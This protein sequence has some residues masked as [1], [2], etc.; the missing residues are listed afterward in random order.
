[1]EHFPNYYG[2]NKNNTCT[3]RVY[4]KILNEIPLSKLTKWYKGNN[5]HERYWRVSILHRLMEPNFLLKH[6]LW[7][8][9]PFVFYM[10]NW[11]WWKKNNVN[12]VVLQSRF[13]TRKYADVEYVNKNNTKL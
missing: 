10:N 9:Q 2:E 6:G 3:F 7:N 13:Y 1:M 4:P 5:Y 8:V 12:T 11:S